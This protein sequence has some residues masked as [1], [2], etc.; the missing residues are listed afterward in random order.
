[1]I[2]NM[3][4]I[5]VSGSKKEKARMIF[6]IRKNNV[7]NIIITGLKEMD[8]ITM[9]CAISQQEHCTLRVVLGQ[10]LTSE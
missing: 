8:G 2:E 3:N 6:S 10:I 1:M 5:K 4:L 9:L 7:D